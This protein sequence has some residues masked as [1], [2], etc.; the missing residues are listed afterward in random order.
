MQPRE[1]KRPRSPLFD[2]E[3]LREF[4]ETNERLDILSPSVDAILP[5]F[6]EGELAFNCEAISQPGEAG[7]TSETILHETI[8]G[9]F[10]TADFFGSPPSAR[11]NTARAMDNVSQERNLSAVSS[12]SL[13]SPLATVTDEPNRGL[14]QRAQQ[15]PN[16]ASARNAS[17]SLC[18]ANGWPDAQTLS[19]DVRKAPST[20]L[21][22]GSLLTENSDKNQSPLRKRS[23]GCGSSASVY[24]SDL[25]S[26][27]CRLLCSGAHIAGVHAESKLNDNVCLSTRGALQT[28][29]RLAL[30]KKSPWCHICTRNCENMPFMLCDN[31]IAGTCTKAICKGC[32]SRFGFGWPDAVS[33]SERPSTEIGWTCIHC[34]NACPPIAYCRVN[35]RGSLK[36]T[37]SASGGRWAIGKRRKV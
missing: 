37:G 23:V 9:S 8:E 30:T 11:N 13:C 25:G 1:S 5:L 33:K 14:P 17:F 31:V 22:A 29:R 15:S 35:G 7:L 16:Y 27:Q 28:E 6:E 10:G 36:A 20:P 4:V 19:C 3:L 18:D 24:T 34:R 2:S 12:G 26:R 32:F 21:S